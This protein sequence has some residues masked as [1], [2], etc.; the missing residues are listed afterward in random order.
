M[1]PAPPVTSSRRYVRA[2]LTASADGPADGRREAALGVVR[3]RHLGRP[4]ER[5]DGPRVGPVALVD[6]AVETALGDVVVEDVR[7]LELA[8]TRR[9]EVVDDRERV[10]P[11]EVHADRDQVALGLLGLLL[12][13]D[14]PPLGVELGDAEAL[15]IRDAIEHR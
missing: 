12:E 6:G 1:N 14:D 3:G 9:Q 13:A 5:G 11:E 10:A 8:T 2:S 7:D 15:R 4:Q